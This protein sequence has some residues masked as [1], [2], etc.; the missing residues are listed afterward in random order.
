MSKPT[1]K[2]MEKH[3]VAMIDSFKKLK[4]AAGGI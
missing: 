4:N 2:V 1:K 3:R